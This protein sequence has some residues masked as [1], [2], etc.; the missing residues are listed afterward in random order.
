M[1]MSID[2]IELKI[3]LIRGHR[4]ILDTDLAIL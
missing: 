3:F 1:P 4:V 2:V